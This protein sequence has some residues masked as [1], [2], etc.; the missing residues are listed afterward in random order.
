MT[1]MD[2]EALPQLTSTANPRVKAVVRLRDRRERERT[3]RT[4]VDGAREIRRALEAGVAIEEAFLCTP[5]LR[6]ADARLALEL[7]RERGVPAWETSEVVFDRLAFGER[8]EGLVVVARVPDT[9][10]DLL[11]VPPDALVVVLEGVEKPG[12]LGAIL[13]SAD[14]AGADA[15]IVAAP[16]TDPFNP[17]VIRASAGTVFAMPL[18]AASSEDVIDWLRERRFRIVAARVDAATSYSDVDLRGP[19]AIAFGSEADGLTGAWEAADIEPV[20]LPMF[21]IADSLNVSVTAA[22]LLYEARRQRGLPARDVYR[23]TQSPRR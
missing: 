1:G 11:D 21:G 7:L 16:R 3:G 2:A 6:G 4:V 23:Q 17:N 9:R 19:V 12:N 20:R 14:G 5:L 22:V 8:A 13:R 18:A 15:L 10:L